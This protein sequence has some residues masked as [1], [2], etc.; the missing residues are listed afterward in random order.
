[1]ADVQVESDGVVV[2]DEAGGRHAAD[3]VVG[4]DGYR[5][6][7]R[8]SILDETPAIRN[9]WVSWQGLTIALPEL[10]GGVHARCIVGPAGL[11]GLMPAGGG[12][13]QWWFDVPVPAADDV[14]VIEWLR[15]RF[16]GYAEP[17][18]AL[19]A[20]LNEADVQEYPHVLHHVPERWG[21]GPTTLLGDAAHAF[22]PSQA[23]GANQALE[24]AWLLRR[25]LDRPRDPVHALRR[26]ERTRARRV[27][28]ISRLAAS[29]VTN[30]PPSA[31]GRFAGRL[32]G[33]RIAGQIYL[34]V[35]RRCSSVLNNEH[36]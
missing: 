36:I 27:R 20:G 23:Q 18:G 12:L 32:A 5:S 31:L 10:A 7:I 28:R 13:L 25:A 8:R 14:P 35:I 1:V 4:A 16:A 6:V 21:N 29:E 33:P 9:G 3:V 15:R 26:Y 24:D 17:V 30:R 22:P 2:I 11:C 34:T 19:L